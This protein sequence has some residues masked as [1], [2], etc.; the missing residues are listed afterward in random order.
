[1]FI[2]SYRLSKFSDRN[3]DVDVVLDLMIHDLDILLWL[4]KYDIIE[5]QAVGVSVW[6]SSLDL[7][8]ARIIFCNGCVANLSVSRVS[9]AKVRTMTIAQPDSVLL[10]NYE[11]GTVGIFSGL[12]RT[13]ADETHSVHEMIKHEGEPLCREIDSFLTCIQQNT[14]PLVSGREGLAA[15]Q[16]AHRVITTIQSYSP[17]SIKTLSEPHKVETDNHR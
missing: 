14:P 8:N 6:S 4:I 9:D 15:L 3:T 12:Q 7:A 11:L 2:D 13:Q 1:M 10:V 16:L 5:V 17:Q